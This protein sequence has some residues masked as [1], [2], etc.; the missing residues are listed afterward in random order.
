[1]TDKPFRRPDY[2][3]YRSADEDKLASVIADQAREELSHARDTLCRYRR[4]V[5]RHPKN[6]YATD[7]T[8][9]MG[10]H[11]YLNSGLWALHAICEKFAGAHDLGRLAK[12][13]QRHC[14]RLDRQIAALA[15]KDEAQVRAVK[16][17]AHAKRMA[18]L[19][20]PIPSRL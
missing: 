6:V 7:R 12:V 17:E 18:E 9:Y 1:M 5:N 2:Y 3:T 16:D 20:R 4:Q 13:I 15:E 14:E 19:L 8:P 10:G 11:M